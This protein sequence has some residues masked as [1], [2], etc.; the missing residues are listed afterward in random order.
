MSKKSNQPAGHFVATPRSLQLGKELL[1]IRNFMRIV[2]TEYIRFCLSLLMNV[3]R[4]ALSLSLVK[5]F[6]QNKLRK[7]VH[8]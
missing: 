2:G 4:T 3:F 6:T 8:L 5:I 1:K 7:Y